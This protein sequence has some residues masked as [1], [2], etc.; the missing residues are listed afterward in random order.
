M[1]HK[2]ANLAWLN[3]V[4]IVRDRTGLITLIAVPLMLTALFGTVLGGGERKMT[5]AVADLD[6]TKLS[7]QVVAALDARSYN[8]LATDEKTVHAMVSSAEAV[9]G[10]VVPAG[11]EHDV[12][13]GVDTT[14]TL[15]KDPRNNGSIAVAQ[16]LQGRIQQI[17]ADAET[18][19]IVRQAYRDASTAAG[20]QLTPPSPSDIYTYANNIWSPEPPVSTSVAEVTRSK[21]RAS[22]EQPMGFSQYSLGFTLMFMLFMG[23]GAAGGF[24]EE[25]EQ[26]T[27]WRLLTTPT[28]RTA[29][30]TGKVVGIYVTV[31]AQAAVMI[32]FGVLVFHVPWGDDPLGVAMLVA[33][34]GLAATGLGVMISALVRTRGQVSAL[35]AV[36]ATA[37]AMLGGAYWPLD[38]VSP[39]MRTVALL[40]P[41]GWGMTGLTDVVVRS[42]GSLAAVLPSAVLLGMA[43]LFLGVGIWRLKFE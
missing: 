6:G 10:V 25:R 3:L 31:I 15:V 26:G 5:V 17:A 16:T 33:S 19:A 35:T 37:M 43:V 41:V 9:A 39:A 21:V 7:R 14:V 4:Q 11:F 34:F 40:T 32:G 38:I 28:S 2:M 42:Q 8:V 18:I 13:G 20:T 29:L 23:M 27:L 30:V 1:L 24:L 12:L 36:G 22:S